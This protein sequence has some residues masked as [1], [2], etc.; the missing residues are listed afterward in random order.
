[1]RYT[2]IAV[3]QGCSEHQKPQQQVEPHVLQE[4]VKRVLSEEDEDGE[5]CEDQTLSRLGSES[6][7]AQVVPEKRGEERS[8]DAHREGADPQRAREAPPSCLRR[9]ERC[10]CCHDEQKT[11][12]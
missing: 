1:M 2:C 11:D 8:N 7:T 9:A 4:H 5:E 3:R 12:A 10:I 6:S